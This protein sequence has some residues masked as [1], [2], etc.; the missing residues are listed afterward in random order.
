MGVWQST[1]GQVQVQGGS[2]QDQSIFYSALLHS[3]VAPTTFSEH[4]VYLGMDGLVHNLTA[5]S[6]AYYSDMSIWSACVC[7][8][9]KADFG[10]T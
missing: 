3:L 1:L 2:A 7:V 6:T 8:F 5:G 10:L 4:G 9:L